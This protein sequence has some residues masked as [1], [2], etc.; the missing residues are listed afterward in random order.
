MAKLNGKKKATLY[1]LFHKD[2]LAGKGVS[3][4]DKLPRNFKNFF[5]ISW[6]HMSHIISV[7]LMFIVGNFPLIFFILGFSQMFNDT[8]A[9]P[10]SS[11][12]PVLFGAT[13]SALDPVSAALYGVHGAHGVMSI[14]TTVTTVM[15]CL[16]ALVIF[17]W[18]WVNVGTTY[19]MRNL[20]KGEPIFFMH[21]FFYAIKRNLKQGLIM[22]IVDSLI[23][24]ILVYDTVF[25]Y[26]NIFYNFPKFLF[27][28]FVM[29]DIVYF[30]MR[31]YI[32]NVL[33]TFDLSVFK[34]IKN[35]F[36]F[37]ALGLKRNAVAFLG[38]AALLLIDYYFLMLLPPLGIILPIIMLYG[39]CAYI[40]TY[41]SWPKIK[42]I[43]VDPYLKAHPEEKPSDDDG[44]IF[45]D[46]VK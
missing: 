1:D 38:I 3:K 41:A 29:L 14:T 25:A 16:G 28:A 12:F 36:I 5:K 21:D 30:I 22:G 45:T 39:Y 10:A 31:F 42:E 19:I 9:S 20:V 26:V 7:N 37:S 17:T 34:I 46:D 33:I 40:G 6:G 2:P 32:Y 23:L 43:M 27:F 15:Y 4:N 13:Q 24:F 11:V 8:I 44:A 18:G 35:A